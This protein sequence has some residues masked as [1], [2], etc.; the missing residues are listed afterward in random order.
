MSPVE[1]KLVVAGAMPAVLTLPHPLTVQTLQALERALSGTL[2]MLRRDLGRASAR[3][4]A[5]STD[6]AASAA[7]RQ[8]AGEIGHAKWLPDAGALEYASWTAHLLTARR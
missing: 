7:S 6:A 1:L 3:Q 8:S 4:S 5:D 2:G